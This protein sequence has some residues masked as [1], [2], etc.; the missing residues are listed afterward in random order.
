M[1]TVHIPPGAGQSYPMIDGD[2]VANARQRAALLR[3]HHAARDP[4]GGRDTGFFSALLVVSCGRVTMAGT[5]ARVVRS[6]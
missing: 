2:H 4:G 5:A 3:R 6:H 1:T